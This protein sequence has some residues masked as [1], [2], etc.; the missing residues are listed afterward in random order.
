M[1]PAVDRMVRGIYERKKEIGSA[2]IQIP[3]KELHIIID[4]DFLLIKT[5]VP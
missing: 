3:V 4:V 2:N 1:K 5:N